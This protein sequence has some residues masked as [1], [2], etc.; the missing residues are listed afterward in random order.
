MSI[1]PEEAINKIIMYNIPTYPFLEELKKAR[2]IRCKC[3]CEGCRYKQHFGCYEYEFNNPD[4]G[5]RG[6][7][8]NIIRLRQENTENDYDSDSESSDSIIEIYD[9]RQSLLWA[10]HNS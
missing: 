2:F 6:I 1:L 10:L 7:S 3:K 8:G 5:K 4:N 9:N